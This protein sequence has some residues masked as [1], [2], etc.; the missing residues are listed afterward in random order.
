MCVYVLCEA[1]R[2]CNAYCSHIHTEARTRP[3]LAFIS[4]K[5]HVSAEPQWNYSSV[6]FIWYISDSDALWTG[7]LLGWE[8]RVVSHS[9]HRYNW[10]LLYSTLLDCK[11]ALTLAQRTPWASPSHQLFLFVSFFFFFFP[12]VVVVV[13][14]RGDESHNVDTATK[15]FAICACACESSAPPIAPPCPVHR[16]F[17]NPIFFFT[18]ISVLFNCVFVNDLSRCLCLWFDAFFYSP[19][20]NCECETTPIALLFWFFICRIFFQRSYIYMCAALPAMHVYFARARTVFSTIIMQFTRQ[21][22][23]NLLAK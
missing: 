18:S 13:L 11:L 19:I 22:W 8:H 16:L 5:Y 12:V 1:G 3:G 6:L 9:T 15:H 14:C 20:V 23:D 10:L 2:P 4:S 7:W 17:E 21:Q